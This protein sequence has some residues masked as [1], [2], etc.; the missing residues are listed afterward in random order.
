MSGKCPEICIGIEVF[1]GG[2][3]RGRLDAW[4][5]FSG[6]VSVGVVHVVQS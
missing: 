2:L 1:A 6:A 4:I 5:A 3:L